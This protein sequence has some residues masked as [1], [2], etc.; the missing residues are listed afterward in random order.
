MSKYGAMAKFVKFAMATVLRNWPTAGEFVTAWWSVSAKHQAAVNRRRKGSRN[1]AAWR[2]ESSAKALENVLK[3]GRNSRN[4]KKV[5]KILGN[6]VSH[7]KSLS[8]I[9]WPGIFRD[10]LSFLVSM[11]DSSLQCSI[12][13][14]SPKEIMAI[15]S[16]CSLK[17]IGRGWC[18]PQAF[19]SHAGIT[20]STFQRMS[21][22]VLEGYSGRWSWKWMGYCQQVG[23]MYG[24]Y[25]YQFY[26]YIYLYLYLYD[27][28]YTC[29][30]IHLCIYLLI[31]LM[32]YLFLSIY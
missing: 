2:G 31:Y 28:L 32:I 25:Y 9:T 18:L 1:L 29:L 4:T 19:L 5:L 16:I 22:E 14:D 11:F 24:L 17:V 27:L 10:V 30:S 21:L 20:L 26:I 6:T 15:W 12:C 3:I 23:Y 13:T 7:G 8:S